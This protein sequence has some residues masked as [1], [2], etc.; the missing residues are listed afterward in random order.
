[1]PDDVVRSI[2][3]KG[4]KVEILGEGA[5]QKVQVDGK[6][7]TASRDPDTGSYHSPDLAY[8]TFT[9]LE[10]LGKAIV[11]AGEGNSA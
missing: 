9:S 6:S 7:A 5:G 3:Y 4:R 1:M 11:D 10:E 8:R 2:D